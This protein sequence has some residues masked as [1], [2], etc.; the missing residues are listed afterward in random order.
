MF[1]IPH[2]GMERYQVI[3]AYDGTHFQGY[4]RQGSVRT[5]Q[6]EVE[7]ALRQLGWQGQTILCAGRTDTGVHASGQVIAFDLEWSHSTEELGRA[8]NAHL[9]KDVAAKAVMQAAPGFHPRFDARARCYRYRLYCQPGRD[10]LR[11]RYAWRVWPAVDGEQ[12]HRAA[13]LITGTHDYAAFGTAMKPGG[14]T[15]RSIFAASWQFEAPDTWVFEIQANA[16]LYRMVRRLVWVQV[17]A[18]QG[19]I[20]LEELQA[21]I[22]NAQPQSPGLAASQGLTLVWVRYS[23]EGQKPEDGMSDTLSASE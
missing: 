11:D 18:A 22:E 7:T 14:S 15:I 20:S 17:I 1:E 13:A 10:P 21:G 9:P 2:R 19:R 16:F 23:P 4:Q 12:L 5:V 6:A 3:L 8:L